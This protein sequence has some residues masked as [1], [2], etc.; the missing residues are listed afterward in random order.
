M[1]K[2]RVILFNE[3]IDMIEKHGSHYTDI[4]LDK[5]SFSI[6]LPS[7]I[8]QKTDEDCK[9]Q[10][11]MTDLPL[12]VSQGRFNDAKAILNSC[13]DG[14]SYFTK[15]L[16]IAYENGLFKCFNLLSDD[17]RSLSVKGY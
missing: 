10:L 13:E 1:S 6:I 12:V 14:H 2:T 16:S 5:G 15:A 7:K 9:T 8:D 4:E 3:F 11:S 17:R